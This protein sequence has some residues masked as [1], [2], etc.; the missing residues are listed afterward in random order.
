MKVFASSFLIKYFCEFTASGQKVHKL[1]SPEQ[2]K[3]DL[4]LFYLFF[5]N[6]FVEFM[7]WKLQLVCV[8]R[9]GGS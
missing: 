5:S 6:V 1:S 3:N 4:L 8:G 2:D 9:D 7:R